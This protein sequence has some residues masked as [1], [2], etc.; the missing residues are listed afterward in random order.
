MKPIGADLG[1]IT[2]GTL[3]LVARFAGWVL[4][5]RVGSAVPVKRYECLDTSHVSAVPWNVPFPVPLDGFPR[6]SFELINLKKKS[7]RRYFG[8]HSGQQPGMVS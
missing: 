6:S 8:E 3:I 7:L 1:F 5:F 4:P 2:L